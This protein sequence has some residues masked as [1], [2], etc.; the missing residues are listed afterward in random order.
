MGICFTTEAKSLYTNGK[1]FLNYYR[2]PPNFIASFVNFYVVNEDDYRKKKAGS[3]KIKAVERIPRAILQRDA[4]VK[5]L[6]YFFNLI[7][8]YQHEAYTQLRSELCF[9]AH[10]TYKTRQAC[11]HK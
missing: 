11:H 9:Y 1:R 3:I 8:N 7:I 5:A 2:P 6:Y 10:S 4:L